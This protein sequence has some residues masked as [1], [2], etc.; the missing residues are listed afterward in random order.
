M[1]DILAKY[2]KFL[3]GTPAAYQALK[4]KDSDTLYFIHQTDAS[5]GKLYLGDVLIAG[6]I[7]ESG[8]NLIDS[9]GELI[10]VNLTGLVKDQVLG[11]N[12][13][14]WVPMT[15]P[16]AVK[17][18]V[19]SGATS[20]TDGTEG[21]VPAPKA[22]QQNYFLRG[23][24]EWAE[25][26][27]P[28]NTQIFEVEINNGADHMSSITN[29]VGENSLQNGDI[30]IVKELINGTKR[31][32]T[33]Y[34]YNNGWKAMDGNY[35]AEN[36]YF[37]ENII[38]TQTVGN[39]E[40]SNNTPVELE[41]AG[42]NLKQLF[43]YLYATEDLDLTIDTPSVSFT[44]SGST[45]GEVGTAVPMPVATLSIS[46]IGSYEYG[47]KDS[48]G[49]VYDAT[50]TGIKFTALRAAYGDTASSAT[51]GNYA[52][53]NNANGMT[54]GKVEF[55]ATNSNITESLFLDS[56]KSY[57]FSYSATYVNDE[58]PRK[59]ITNLGN[60]IDTNGIATAEYSNGTKALE[61][62]TLTGTKTHTVTGYRKWFWG[63]MS[64][65]DALADPTQIT[66]EQIRALQKSK[67]SGIDSYTQTS[68]WVVPAGTKQIYIA[69]P[70]GKKGTLT[71]N[72]WS[73]LGSE[74]AC[75]KVASGV[76]VADA[77]GTV[78]GVVQGGMAYDL[79]YVNP[80][81]AFGSDAKLALTWS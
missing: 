14:A 69:I 55:T 32:Y 31:Q 15:L 44:L 47:S 66:S 80:D 52:D 29:V 30:A 26:K 45:S 77:R 79:W 6:N 64:A 42:K 5:Y 37:D 23:D 18:S 75:T 43:E 46:D 54:S 12:G 24:G 67:A 10:D 34:V 74:V 16:E 39:I 60:F 3:R 2:V 7:T 59:P 50:N 57:T 4:E 19:M 65:D 8:D 62:K 63:Y 78:D 73:S 20:E 61:G 51:S 33:A 38:V 56:G 9:L 1:A 17:V 27:V 21:L 58:N 13:T 40:T 76:T 53:N 71:I 48:E 70:A 81:G 72:N 25:V 35:N 22:G 11:Y 41:V 49:A 68:P 36:V 28:S